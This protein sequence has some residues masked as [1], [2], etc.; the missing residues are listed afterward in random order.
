MVGL[1]ATI[2][3]FFDERGVLGVDA[4]NRGEHDGVVPVAPVNPPSASG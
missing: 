3:G 1:V 4:R 2:L